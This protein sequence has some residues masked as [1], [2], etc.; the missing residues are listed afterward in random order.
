MS[1]R[2]VHKLAPKFYGPFKVLRRIG[3]VAY[4]LELPEHSR[5]HDVFHISLLKPFKGDP[6]SRMPSLPPFKN[7]N[8]I[9]QPQF[10]VRSR[11]NRGA[12][13]VLVEWAHLPVA[14]ATGIPLTVFQE[15][16]PEFELADKLFVQEGSN[17]VDAFIGK[18]YSRKQ[19]Q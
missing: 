15:T 10:I 4:Q 3:E 12:V 11:I 6:P 7:G 18:K 19:Q 17:V 13:D 1:R 16:Y 2:A 5:I 8:V 14:E 9:S